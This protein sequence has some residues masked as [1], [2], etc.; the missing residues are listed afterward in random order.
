[1]ALLVD[2]PDLVVANSYDTSLTEVNAS[3]GA[4]VRVVST[5]ALVRVV[6]GPS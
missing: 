1:V 3:T 2:G 6:S 5:G 4:L